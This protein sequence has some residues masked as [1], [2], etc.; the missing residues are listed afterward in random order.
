MITMGIQD[1]KQLTTVNP[2]YIDISASPS[3]LDFAGR[4]PACKFI[5]RFRLTNVTLST[6]MVNVETPY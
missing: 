3:F 4:Y 5:Y 1:L 2:S 6:S